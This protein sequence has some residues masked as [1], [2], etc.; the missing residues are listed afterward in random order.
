MKKII[1]SLV[2]L[3]WVNISFAKNIVVLTS[4][5]TKDIRAIKKITKI[6]KKKLANFRDYKLVLKNYANQDDLY[7]ELNDPNTFALFWVSHGA[8]VKNQNE[9]QSMG[10]SPL[11]LDYQKDNIA[12]VFKLIHPNIKFL[13]II[14]CNSAQILENEVFKSLETAAYLPAKKVIATWGFRRA[15][16]KFRRHISSHYFNY[17]DS[18]IEKIGHRILITRKVVKDSKS[19]KVFAGKSLIG[20]LPKLS[21]N[22]TQTKEFYIPIDSSL[23]IK[24]SSGQ[25]AFDSTDNFGNISIHYNNHQTLWKLFAKPNGEAFGVN[26]RLFLFKGTGQEFDQGEKY[27]RFNN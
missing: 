1:I 24:I 7:K 25:S 16:R 21:A 15:I 19:L 12:S 3:I 4:L 18:P 6:A 27:I 14:G 23:K 26:E 20:L 5:P 9:N 17:I 8:Y 10:A 22:M 13:G 11:L 2:A